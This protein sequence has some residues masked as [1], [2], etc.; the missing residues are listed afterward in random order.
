LDPPVAKELALT[1]LFS[2]TALI[3]L[4]L[5]AVV[6]ISAC[7]GSSGGGGAQAIV[8]QTFSGTHKKVTSGNIALTLGV[9]SQPSTSG[10]VSVK[11]NGPFQSTGTGQ[12]PSF[13]LALV[14]N[15]KGQAISAGAV[16]TGQAGFISFEGQDYSIPAPVFAQ[17][18]QGF[19]QAESQNKSAKGKSGLSALGINPAD[20]LNNLKSEGTT[21]VGGTNT[22]HVSAQLNVASLLNDLSQILAKAGS[23]GVNTAG[24]VPTQLSAQQRQA[25]ESAVKT[26]TIDIYSGKDD[27]ILRRLSLTIGIAPKAGE[28][29]NVNFDLQ[30]TGVDQPQTIAAPTNVQ[31]LSKLKSSLGGLGGLGSLL[32]GSGASA[33]GAGGA[34]PATPAPASSSASSTSAQAYLACVQAAGSDSA[35]AAQCLSLVAK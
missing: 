34:A 32:G 22:N 7:G 26:S 11:L 27:S 10:A 28:S 29:A 2:R 20:W 25:I 21:D 18:K 14:I 17:F 33:S 16:S 5:A 6:G 30:I 15:V 4:L 19:L 9:T 13:N 24:K 23:L 31:P 35:K 8:K 12:L 1:R 3:S